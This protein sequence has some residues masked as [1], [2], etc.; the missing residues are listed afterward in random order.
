MKLTIGDRLLSFTIDNAN[1]SIYISL[2]D[3]EI[4]LAFQI[5]QQYFH[6][7]K[8]HKYTYLDAHIPCLLFFCY[9]K[10]RT[11]QT[12]LGC[13]DIEGHKKSSAIK[14]ISKGMIR[15]EWSHSY[16]NYL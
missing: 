15:W 16:T 10:E 11:H 7:H 13:E 9:T 6:I 1:K 12:G 5:H 3:D 2:K 4:W 8:P 14:V